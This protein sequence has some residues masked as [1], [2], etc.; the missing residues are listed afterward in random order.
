MLKLNS[1]IQQLPQQEKFPCTFFTDSPFYAETFP[2][3]IKQSAI[4]E[5][6]LN[7]SRLKEFCQSQKIRTAEG[8]CADKFDSLAAWAVNRNK[9]PMVLKTSQNLSDSEGIYLLKAFRELPEFFEKIATI[10]PA[11]FII[12]EFIQG[13]GYIEVAVLG[14]KIV[15][16][17]QISLEKSMRMRH[18]WRLF[19]IKLPASL[20][21][22]IRN[23]ILKIPA[24]SDSKSVPL[25]FSFAIN[26]MEP[27]LLSINVGINRPEYHPD[28]SEAAGINNIFTRPPQC[29]A[30]ICKVMNFFEV[31]ATE[32]SWTEIERL[33][34]KSLARYALTGEQAIVLLSCD[35][36]PTLLEYSK[37]VAAYFKHIIR[38]KSVIQPDSED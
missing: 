24:V 12:E 22:N 23:I 26:A 3:E 13:K 19:P 31:D 34:G 21:E 8:K 29:G 18:S 5:L 30:R 37:R 15:M 10:K 38:P 25:R 6:I 14:G 2:A 11:S 33:C 20:L 35:D 9:F 16:V 28:W 1:Q 7:R 32:I 36:A 27:T 17:S 4:Y